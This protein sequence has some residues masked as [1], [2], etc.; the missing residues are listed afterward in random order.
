M[1]RDPD[2]R[3]SCA[4]PAARD[5]RRVWAGNAV[6]GTAAVLTLLAA[7]RLFVPGARPGLDLAVL[8]T[9]ALTLALPGH[10][11]ALCMMPDMRCRS[12][13]LPAVTVLSILIAAVAAVDFI[14]QRGKG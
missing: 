14:L 1:E 5:L 7:L 12:V 9:A 11:I 10:L 2:R 4:V 8:A 6:A 13:M 3:N